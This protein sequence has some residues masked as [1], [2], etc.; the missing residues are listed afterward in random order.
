MKFRTWIRE[1][2]YPPRKASISS[3]DKSRRLISNNSRLLYF[4]PTKSKFLIPLRKNISC[5]ENWYFSL[6]THIYDILDRRRSC[7]RSFWFATRFAG[8]SVRWNFI[9]S[10]D[11][12]WQ[13]HPFPHKNYFTLK[14]GDLQNSFLTRKTWPSE[15]VLRPW[16]L[17]S[18]FCFSLK[19]PELQS[20]HS[21]P[22]LKFF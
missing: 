22:E 21:R 17:P 15:H 3:I 18:D 1:G 9:F 10:V 5:F 16:I 12:F 13:V 8:P 11:K 4:M 6:F 7:V 19:L 2:V 14:G 20:P